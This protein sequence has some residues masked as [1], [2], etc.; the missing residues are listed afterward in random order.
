MLLSSLSLEAQDPTPVAS[1]AKAKAEIEQVLE[2]KYSLDKDLIIIDSSGPIQFTPIL[3]NFLKTLREG[4]A[5]PGL[6]EDVRRLTFG[7]LTKVHAQE[8]SYDSSIKLTLPSNF[9]S[10]TILQLIE[11]RL[12]IY[13]QNLQLR[14]EIDAILKARHNYAGKA[15]S[16]T[17][18]FYTNNAMATY[19]PVEP[20]DT[21]ETAEV[22]ESFKTLI[23]QQQ[24]DL[25]EVDRLYLTRE[26]RSVEMFR[27][28]RR[29]L[30]L[31]IPNAA[32]I[33]GLDI[34]GQ[35]NG[36]LEFHKS[37]QETLELFKTCCAYPYNNFAQNS[38]ASDREI[39]KALQQIERDF[40]NTTVLPNLQD[41]GEIEFWSGN[42]V[43]VEPL[44]KLLK[45]SWKISI[46][47]N[48]DGNLANSIKEHL[49]S[50]REF[51][52]QMR[53]LLN[54][55]AQL[56]REKHKYR[57]S[58]AR[59]KAVNDTRFASA[60]WVLKDF[61]ET[62]APISEL[63]GIRA[64]SIS[65]GQNISLSASHGLEL[66]AGISIDFLKENLPRAFFEYQL[67]K[68][69][70]ALLKEQGARIPRVS[71]DPKISRSNF[72][73]GL[74]NFKEL[75][76]S[77]PDLKLSN[78]RNV[79]ISSER[80]V[81]TYRQPY[82]S[83]LD[84]LIPFDMKSDFLR[85]GL[86]TKLGFYLDLDSAKYEV[87]HL[88]RLNHGYKGSDISPSNSVSEED[89]LPTLEALL[90]ALEDNTFDFSEV[91]EIIVNSEN[92]ASLRYKSARRRNIQTKRL[93]LYLPVKVPEGTSLS[94]L[95]SNEFGLHQ[96]KKDVAALLKERHG[97]AGEALPQ[98]FGNLDRSL[99]TQLLKDI[100]VS[101]ET[102]DTVLDLSDVGSLF[103]ADRETVWVRSDSDD[104]ISLIL[105]SNVP[106]DHLVPLIQIALF[107]PEEIEQEVNI[108]LKKR[109]YLGAPL[110]NYPH[111]E[112]EDFD[113]EKLL[114]KLLTG[115]KTAKF[116]IDL[117]PV[118]HIWLMGTKGRIRLS[119]HPD[120]STIL[121]LPQNLPD[122][123]IH[124]S[125]SSL[126]IPQLTGKIGQLLEQ[127]NHAITLSFSEWSASEEEV[128]RGLE[129]LHT[130]LASN[131]S[132]QGLSGI[133]RIVL[134]GNRGKLWIFE[135]TLYLPS[136]TSGEEIADL[137]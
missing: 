134:T 91:R 111:F 95:L 19:L 8:T 16:L 82:G 119:P 133:E 63:A 61:L 125:F 55:V 99:F 120:A 23:Q 85:S 117:N 109:G 135:K 32:G 78:V 121:I 73:Q 127:R 81:R 22:L 136:S 35:L 12:K 4:D 15:T 101:F 106:A 118:G 62:S 3:N 112:M 80:V 27:S 25:S 60:L 42:G 57:G 90:K 67:E 100:Q 65:A 43:K 48:F 14:K 13:R 54:E 86:D 69:V 74:T 96:I 6:F 113:Y 114:E 116:A 31:Y 76:T 20:I 59:D 108:E 137:L 28:P 75:L 37:K 50:H 98:A 107:T 56:L 58:L 70:L 115:M 39:G 29:E 128:A 51:R 41:V 132:L 34:T 38:Q 122:G 10:D 7:R 64:L 110:Q 17:A 79:A 83:G 92:L 46:P 45:A 21:L 77:H 102:S 130:L 44:N 97:Y 129:K 30:F 103:L 71:A 68:D 105:P 1:L 66:P 5:R 36:K 52:R 126:A 2:Q 94:S 9:S 93:A 131:L 18:R 104:K 87:H 40:S 88:L 26:G 84:I 123:P 11:E 53:Q 47:T 49:D 89:S 33:P 72:I 24:F 124:V